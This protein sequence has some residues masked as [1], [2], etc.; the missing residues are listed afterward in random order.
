MPDLTDY[1]S[2]ADTAKV[3]GVRPLTLDRWRANRRGPPYTRLGHKVLYKKSSLAEWF[4]AQEQMA[5]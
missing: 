2:R 4:N 5:A 3:L 1:L